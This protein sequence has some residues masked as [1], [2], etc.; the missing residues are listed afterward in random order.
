MGDCVNID[1]DCTVKKTEN[2]VETVVD[3]ELVL[4]HIV[5]GQFYSLKDT[6]R[7]AWNLLD[8]HPR[9]G[10][11]VDAMRQTYDVDEETCRNELQKLIGD[12]AKRTLVEVS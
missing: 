6:G 3:D 9:F 12:L 8:E 2:F 11:L 10:E 4:L 7:T 1:N 5:N